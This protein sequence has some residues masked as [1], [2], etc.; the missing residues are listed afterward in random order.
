MCMYVCRSVYAACVYRC[1]HVGVYTKGCVCVYG[2][3]VFVG[4]CRYMHAGVCTQ[5]YMSGTLQVVHA[6]GLWR[7]CVYVCMCVGMC[8]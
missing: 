3:C 8:T 6:L 2:V 1:V 5:L 7:V 4:V